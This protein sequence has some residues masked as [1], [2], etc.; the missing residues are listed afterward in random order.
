MKLYDLTITM[1]DG[2]V[3][4]LRRRNEQSTRTMTKFFEG[5]GDTVE[6]THV[7]FESDRPQFR[8][9]TES[10]EVVPNV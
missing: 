6:S 7:G 9:D 5:F 4:H 3:I 2:H 1:T 10:G 8:H